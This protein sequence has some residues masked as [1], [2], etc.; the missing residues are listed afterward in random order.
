[1]NQ[2]SVYLDCMRCYE[3]QGQIDHEEN[4]FFTLQAGNE[5]HRLR[6]QVINNIRPHDTIERMMCDYSQFPDDPNSNKKREQ[7]K[8]LSACINCDKSKP[9]IAIVTKKMEG[10]S[11]LLELSAESK[12]KVHNYRGNAKD[13]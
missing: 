1:M 5:Q 12:E 7:I 2:I 13:E 11:G 6:E 9:L 8:L 4:P 10:F 3:L